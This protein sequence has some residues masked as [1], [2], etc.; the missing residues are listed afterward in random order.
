MAKTTKFNAFKMQL[1]SLSEALAQVCYRKSER[2]ASLVHN[3]KLTGTIR[4][5]FRVHEFNGH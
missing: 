5:K 4:G 1:L 3:Q 2:R